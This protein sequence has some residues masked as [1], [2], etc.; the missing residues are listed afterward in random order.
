MISALIN[1]L[2]GE[3]PKLLVRTA[4]STGDYLEGVFSRDDLPRCYELLR[5]TLGA[6]V[7]DFGQPVNF[8]PDIRPVV[9][10]VGGCRADQCLFL[11]PDDQGRT[12]YAALWPWASDKARITLKVGVYDPQAG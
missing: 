8:K 3:L 1:A 2:R 4:P 5:K 9:D 12:V 10:K 11:A 6:P 7:K